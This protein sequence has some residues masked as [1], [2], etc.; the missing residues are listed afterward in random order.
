MPTPNDFPTTT[1][2][3]IQDEWSE[4]PLCHEI[5]KAPRQYTGDMCSCRRV[6]TGRYDLRIR[7]EDDYIYIIRDDVALKYKNYFEISE[8]EI[9]K[10]ST[11]RIE[12]MFPDLHYMDDVQI[13]PVI[14]YCL[15]NNIIKTF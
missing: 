10:I 15:E 8:S 14:Q 13:Q 6:P 7:I 3:S 2:S 1:K 4:C 9:Q 12:N 11:K 5:D